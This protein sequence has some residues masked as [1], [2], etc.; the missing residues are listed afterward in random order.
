L[1]IVDFG[2]LIVHLQDTGGSLAWLF[3]CRF[4]KLL[5][6]VDAMEVVVFLF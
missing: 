1:F 4:E 5:V 3:K 2:G 6:N